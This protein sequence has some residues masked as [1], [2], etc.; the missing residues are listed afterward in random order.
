MARKIRSGI[1]VTKT[2][3]EFFGYQMESYILREASKKEAERG[4][5]RLLF[6]G[7]DT[8]CKSWLDR[9]PLSVAQW[10][11]S[12]LRDGPKGGRAR[13]VFSF[14]S[15]D[16]PLWIIK[17]L[18]SSYHQ[19]QVLSSD[20]GRARDLVGLV[21]MSEDARALSHID[22]EFIGASSE[23]RRGCMVGFELASYSY[24]NPNAAKF[25][26]LKFQNV[27]ES[28]LQ[29]AAHIGVA[30]NLARHATNLPPATLTPRTYADS[31]KKL[32]SKAKDISVDIWDRDRL[33]KERCTLHLTVGQAAV[34]SAVLVH[35]RYRPKA[36]RKPWA[37]VGKG[38]TFDSGGLDI[39]PASGMRWMK[40]D[41]AGSATLL[42]LAYALTARHC[43]QAVDI[44]LALAENAVSASAFHPG[45]VIKS[46]NGL[47]VE[48]H[49]TDAEGRLVLADAIDVAIKRDAADKPRGVIDLATLTGAMKVALGTEVVG[50]F[51]NHDE[52]GALFLRHANK[53]AEKAWRLPLVKEYEAEL[54]STVA[55]LANASSSGFGGAITAALF[56][57]RFVGDLPWL[58]ADMYG[59]TDRPSGSLLEQGANGQL[60]QTLITLVEELSSI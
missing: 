10:Q 4:R 34:D 57:E 6:F 13:E 38:V 12:T 32:F 53:Q 58:H 39:K 21:M 30:T 51:A 23:E 3:Q 9:H 1:H 5:G 28:E 42:G 19:K 40:K 26:Y 60:V 33:H 48:I 55:D 8:D 31:I 56:L 27:S 45:D 14:A 46:R 59:W 20:Y 16:G 35:I 22:A 17:P 41:M 43:Q 11:L 2:K 50:I 25:P 49:N 7:A 36:S 15:A 47:S 18:R 37:F 24:R 44:Y 52:L 29:E 54:K